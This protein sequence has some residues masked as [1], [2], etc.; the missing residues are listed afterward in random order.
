[1]T[2]NRWDGTLNGVKFRLRRGEGAYNRFF[3]R[4]QVEEQFILPTGDR[5]SR[6]DRRIHMQTNWADGATWFR[7]L[8]EEQFQSTYQYAQ[9]MDMLREPG[10][11]LPLNQRNADTR[12]TRGMEA[13]SP[14]TNVL[15]FYSGAGVGPQTTVIGVSNTAGTNRPLRYWDHVGAA[16]TDSTGTVGSV[17]TKWQLIQ[18]GSDIFA[19]DN[20]YISWTDGTSTT[21]NDAVAVSPRYGASIAPG[22]LG[23]VFFYD[24][25][26]LYEV[27]TVNKTLDAVTD[28]GL[29]PT[30][31]LSDWADYAPQAMRH[32]IGTTEG[33]YYMKNIWVSGGPQCWIYRVE[34]DAAGNIISVPL[35]TLPTGVLGLSL[36]W[37]LGTPV[38][39]AT[40]DWTYALGGESG[41]ENGP[42]ETQLWSLF[43]GTQGVLGSFNH[44]EPNAYAITRPVA[45]VYSILG[46]F[47]GALVMGGSNVMWIYDPVRGGAHPL[48]KIVPQD[49]HNYNFAINAANDRVILDDDYFL[50]PRGGFDF[51]ESDFGGI[52]DNSYYVWSNWFDYDLPGEQKTITGIKTRI[53]DYNQRATAKWVVD[54]YDASAA[55][56]GSPFPATPEHVHT[57][58]NQEAE[59]TGLSLTSE[60]FFYKIQYRTDTGTGASAPPGLVGI[61]FTAQTGEV[62]QGWQL[63]IDGSEFRNVE[64]EHQDP[65]AVYDSWVT[66]GQNDTAITFV[67]SFEAYDRDDE[68]THTVRIESVQITKQDPGEAQI[69]VT[70]IDAS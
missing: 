30:I 32:C 40:D 20:T 18:I 43:G 47:R 68:G 41:A 3:S 69:Q 63:T 14:I 13:D 52:E 17:T 31:R 57:C 1:M 8:L 61:W 56:F 19:L 70:L 58:D 53:T 4:Q 38:I 10:T 29:G 60:R 11:I 9:N 36:G 49:K 28:D 21:D 46:T 42:F 23:Q 59:T 7:P 55:G 67:D 25:D 44:Q 34:R 16:W 12:P 5:T 24:G 65:E 27:D 37:V 62:V 22:L 39:L 35:A 33:V 2:E 66:L 51:P 64:N 6:Q 50:H 15:N 54:V 48:F 45:G 26:V